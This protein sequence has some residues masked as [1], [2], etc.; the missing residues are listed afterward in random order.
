[1]KNDLSRQVALV[2]GS[3][4]GIGKAIALA[5]AAAGA[6]VAISDLVEDDGNLEAAAGDIRRLGR[7]ALAIKADVSRKAEIE[8][9]V[10]LTVQ[11]FGKIDILVNCAG[12]WIPGQTLLECSEENWDKVIDTNLKSMYFCCQAA[13]KLMVNRKS[14]N[15]I[16]LASQNA[17]Y[18]GIGIGAYAVSKAGI[19]M[20]T[21]QLAL[22]LA[23]YNIRVNALAPGV[24]QTDFNRGVWEDPQVRDRIT[25]GIPLGRMA[26]P[27]DVA[28]AAVFLASESSRY[29]TGEVLS[30][31]GGWRPPVIQDL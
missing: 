2:T 8:N 25:R 6:D 16:N 27:E 18:P 10:Q 26:A 1:M 23:R 21:R 20:L 5:L 28:D 12:V 31:S 3:R 4:R 14:G 15:I 22:E 11:Q 30:V 9:M 29:V 19:A 13:G 7:R 17:L 24:V